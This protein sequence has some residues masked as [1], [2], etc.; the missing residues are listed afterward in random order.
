LAK[1]TELT[2]PFHFETAYP[3]CTSKLTGIFKS[4]G[5]QHFKA[6]QKQL[7]SQNADQVWEESY[8]KKFMGALIMHSS[9]IKRNFRSQSGNSAARSSYA[10]TENM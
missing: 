4:E 2:K 10:S 8:D 5:I 3:L 7:I 9:K 1:Y 6:V